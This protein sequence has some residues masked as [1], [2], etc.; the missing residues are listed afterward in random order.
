V[1]GAARSPVLG[2]GGTRKTLGSQNSISVGPTTDCPDCGEFNIGSNGQL[3]LVLFAQGFVGAALFVGFFLSVAVAFW[4][5]PGITAAA[6]VLV[7]L[8]AVFYSVFYSAFPGALTL[9]MISI[10][11]MVRDRGLQDSAG[12]AP[13]GGARRPS[14]AVSV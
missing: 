13:L 4:R 3:W 12:G 6:G 7:A 11:V 14:V 2:Y 1:D 8:L 9:T 10:G 5:E